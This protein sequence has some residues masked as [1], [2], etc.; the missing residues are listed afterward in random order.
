[1]IRHA[2]YVAAIGEGV[3]ASDDHGETF[4]R[5]CDGMPFVECY[6]RALAVDPAEPATLFLGNE[7]GVWV[8]RDAAENWTCA[9]PLD[10]RSVWSL[11][12]QGKRVIAGTCPS[13]LYRSSDGGAT[14]AEAAAT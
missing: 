11:R 12:V 4:R 5:A 3:F 7:T 2:L 6:V 8:S 13:R 14:W 1:M 10:N 9:L